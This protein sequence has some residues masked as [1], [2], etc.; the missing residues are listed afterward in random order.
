M[1]TFDLQL[2]YGLMSV[3]E[4]A[5][6]LLS[7]K[8]TCTRPG[9]GSVKLHGISARQ[10]VEAVLLLE[11]F[12]QK[13]DWVCNILLRANTPEEVKQI[14]EVLGTVAKYGSHRP[15]ID[16]S[17]CLTVVTPSVDWSMLAETSL[18]LFLQEE[19]E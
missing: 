6:D 17:D 10:M 4:H 3:A 12:M 9:I 19:E 14:L 11:E 8:F 16:N 18:T 2:Y 13:N 15:F 1:K 7:K 5:E